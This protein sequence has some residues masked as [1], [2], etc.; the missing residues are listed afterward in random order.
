MNFNHILARVLNKFNQLDVKQVAK[1]R[2]KAEWFR[3]LS[4]VNIPPNLQERLTLG[5]QLS[6]YQKKY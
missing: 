5:P 3:N 1:Y 6:V 4:N 2:A